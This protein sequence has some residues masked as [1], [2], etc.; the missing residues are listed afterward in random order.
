[1]M[2]ASSTKHK[3]ER[4]QEERAQKRGGKNGKEPNKE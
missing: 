1:M 4:D 3:R 2:M